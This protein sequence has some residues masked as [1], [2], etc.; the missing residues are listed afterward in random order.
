M[1]VIL[2]GLDE[3]GQA[4]YTVVED[5]ASFCRWDQSLDR[6]N[7]VIVTCR[8]ASY[9][10]EDPRDSIPEVVGVEPFTNH[11]MRTFL[12]WPDTPNTRGDSRLLAFFM[13]S[14]PQWSHCRGRV[15]IASRCVPTPLRRIPLP[16]PVARHARP[17]ST[18]RVWEA[19]KCSSPGRR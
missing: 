6:R 16:V 3:V 19:G 4:R 7:R 9:R 8:E 1:L 12:S 17:P 15:P 2:D 10:D 18:H 5:I 11:H 13:D 14:E